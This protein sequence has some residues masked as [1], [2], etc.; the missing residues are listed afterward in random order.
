MDKIGTYALLFFIAGI[1]IF[2]LFRRVPVF[3]TF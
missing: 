2:A 3:D 1:F